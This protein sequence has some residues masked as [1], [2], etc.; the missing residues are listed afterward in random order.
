MNTQEVFILLTNQSLDA[1]WFLS[2]PEQPEL[3]ALGQ[4]VLIIMTLGWLFH[5]VPSLVKGVCH[6]GPSWNPPPHSQQS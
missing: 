5:L 3:L 2:I 6:Q 4:L 1:V